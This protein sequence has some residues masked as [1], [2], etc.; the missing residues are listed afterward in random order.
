MQQQYYKAMH[1]KPAVQKKRITELN[2]K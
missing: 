1:I 2:R